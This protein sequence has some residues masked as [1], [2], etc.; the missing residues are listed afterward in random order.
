MIEAIVELGYRPEIVRSPIDVGASLIERGIESGAPTPEPL[1]SALREAAETSKL[2][3]VDF[4]AEWC[5]ACKTMDRTTFKDPAVLSALEGYVFIKVDADLHPRAARHFNVAG[6]P[7][8][9]VLD[10]SG[11]EIYRQVGPIE[12]SRLARELSLLTRP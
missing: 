2:V 5:G 7:T 1:V 8:L 4:Y 11:N 3:F 6:M 9:V 12:A 10:T